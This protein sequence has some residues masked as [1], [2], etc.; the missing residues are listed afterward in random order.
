MM[1]SCLP[2]GGQP[3][4]TPTDEA[5]DVDASGIRVRPCLCEGRLGAEEGGD[6]PGKGFVSYRGMIQSPYPVGPLP[7][8][9]PDAPRKDKGEHEYQKHP[10]PQ[11][12]PW[13]SHG[14]VLRPANTKT[15]SLPG[16][17]RFA[18]DVSRP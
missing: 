16:P 3:H 7:L 8:L 1:S 11:P 6:L 12:H 10:R 17:S 13:E 18:V 5:A 2:A 15:S 9:P 14:A 4:A